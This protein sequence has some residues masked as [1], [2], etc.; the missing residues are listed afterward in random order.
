MNAKEL[1]DELNGQGITLLWDSGSLYWD[2]PFEYAPSDEIVELVKKNKDEIARRI[3]G[4]VLEELFSGTNIVKLIGGDCLGAMKRYPDNLIDLIVTDPPYGYQFMGKDWD[5]AVPSVEIWKECLRVLKSGGFAFIMS[6]PRQD[7]LARMIVNLQEAGFNTGFT[8]LYWTYVSGFPKAYNISKAIDKKAGVK[9]TALCRNPNSREDCDKSSTIYQ[10]GTVGKTAYITE[11]TTP[12]AE[13]LDGSYGGYQPKP[14]V[15]VIL[16]VQKP[17]SEKTYADQAMVNGKGVTWLNDCR[18]HSGDEAVWSAE[19]GVQWSPEK[20]WN[21]DTKQAGSA[22][23]RFPANLLV[24]DNILDQACTHKGGFS[25][26]FSLDAWVGQNIDALHIDA[27]EEFDQQVLPFLIVPKASKKEKDFGTDGLRG[28]R[29]GDKG[30]G[31]GRICEHCGSPQ[32]NPCDCEPKSWI[33]PK[34]KNFHPTVK[35]ILLMAYLITMGSREGEIV[36]DPFCG[37][38]TTCLAARLRKRPCIGIEKNPEYFNLAAARM[39]ELNLLSHIG[40]EQQKAS[41]TKKAEE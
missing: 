21:Q 32:L 33:H 25:K 7:V 3:N 5:K 6:A 18:I 26:F 9:R 41:G 28:Q 37:S 34:R 40:Q 39:R 27:L 20:E 23:G 31:L 30:D 12:E 17:L 36:L 22:S 2:A 10:S 15:E 1:I 35:P 11:P 13:A 24:S 19:G 4:P 38:G 16:I 14:A 29:V 8:S